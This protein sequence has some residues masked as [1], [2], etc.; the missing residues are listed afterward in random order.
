MHVGENGYGRGL[1][2][3]ES[4]L[5]FER[6]RGMRLVNLR[7]FDGEAIKET[8]LAMIPIRIRNAD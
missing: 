5:I 4:P 3:M 1:S 7:I 8:A 2:V 6:I